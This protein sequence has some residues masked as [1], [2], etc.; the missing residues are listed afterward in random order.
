M[1]RSKNNPA[2]MIFRNALRSFTVLFFS[3]FAFILFI[4]IFPLIGSFTT[5][6]F[7][8]QQVIKDNFK[9]LVPLFIASVLISPLFGIAATTIRKKRF[10]FLFLIGIGGCLLAI[11]S[12]MLFWS[13]L[14]VAKEDLSS[15]AAISLWALAAY[16]FF[17]LPILVPAII[18]IERW[19]REKQDTNRL[20]NAS[21][22]IK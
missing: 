18:I 15:F 9:L 11:I 16:S 12:V 19:T 13:G 3:S 21:S 6:H 20:E 22:Q 2:G 4:T 10:L 8:I 7:P 14:T 5:T 17:S 1:N